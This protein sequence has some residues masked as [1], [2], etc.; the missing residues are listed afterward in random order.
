M[1]HQIW[2]HWLQYERK[3]RYLP[4][5]IFKLFYLLSSLNF[6]FYPV[7]LKN[8]KLGLSRPHFQHSFLNT[9]DSLNMPM[10]GF[11]PRVSGVRRNCPTNCATTT[12]QSVVHFLKDELFSSPN[13][14]LGFAQVKIGSE[15]DSPGLVVMGED[16]CSKGHEFKSQHRILDRHFSHMY[17]L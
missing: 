5:S 14:K 9:I 11:K 13:I 7:H 10:T 16:S 3:F 4:R 8:K 12:A 2:S 1:F 15:G 17:L 6:D